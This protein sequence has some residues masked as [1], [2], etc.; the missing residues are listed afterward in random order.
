M[1]V[2]KCGCR[3]LTGPLEASSALCSSLGL[4]C[5]LFRLAFPNLCWCWQRLVISDTASWGRA[6][7]RKKQRSAGGGNFHVNRPQQE[8]GR[9][10]YQTTELETPFPSEEH[11]RFFL[12]CSVRFASPELQHCVSGTLKTGNDLQFIRMGFTPSH[13]LFHGHCQGCLTPILQV[14]GT[15]GSCRK[16][17]C[18]F[19]KQGERTLQG[20]PDGKTCVGLDVV[21][22][23]ERVS[24]D[25]QDI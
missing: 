4:F 17:F 2:N 6:T 14:L 8:G 16:P 24:Q 1:E 9:H 7:P 3:L 21:P 11:P 25:D 18:V 10:G 15:Q 19:L 12:G 5:L 20:T 22:H 13:C 23:P